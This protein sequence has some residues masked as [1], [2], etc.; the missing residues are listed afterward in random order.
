MAR[1]D[2]QVSG[3][4][5]I[6]GREARTVG[7]LKKSLGVPGYNAQVNGDP[8]SDNYTL[9]ERAFVTLTENVKGA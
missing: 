9:Q 2:V 4:D 1:V 8:Q 7:D 3:G 5:I 6:R